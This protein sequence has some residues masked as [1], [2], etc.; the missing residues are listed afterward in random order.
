MKKKNL[1]EIMVRAI[2]IFISC[3]TKT[4]P[5]ERLGDF[6]LLDCDRSRNGTGQNFLDPT[7]KF[8]N[9]R[10]LTGPVDR[11]FTEDFCSLFSASNEK[12]S[13]GGAWVRC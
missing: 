10:R 12:F 5:I 8:Q 9:L 1:P 11:F 4:S 7:G 6:L 3:R 13:K 2:I